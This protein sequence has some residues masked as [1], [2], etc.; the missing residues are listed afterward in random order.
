MNLITHSDF[1]NLILPNY[2]NI[3]YFF[4]KK[5][6]FKREGELNNGHTLNGNDY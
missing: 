1:G 3:S 6:Y 5:K 2:L 4:I